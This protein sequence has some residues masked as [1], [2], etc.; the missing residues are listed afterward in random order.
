MQ[1]CFYWVG[2]N[3]GR[4]DHETFLSDEQ[5]IIAFMFCIPLDVRAVLLS[6]RLP[7][8]V[9]VEIENDRGADDNPSRFEPTGHY[10]RE[11]P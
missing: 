3:D 2:R 6:A 11:R 9:E 7:P 5:T 8:L 10:H 4:T 1:D